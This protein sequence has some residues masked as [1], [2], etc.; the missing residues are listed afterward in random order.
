MAETAPLYCDYAATAPIRPEVTAAIAP[1]L[2]RAVGNPAALHP[3]GEEAKNTLEQARTLVANVFASATKNV[4]EEDVLFT[5]GGTEANNLAIKGLALANPRGKHIVTSTIEHPA[6]HEPL[7]QLEKWHGFEVDYAPVTADGVVD[8]KAFEQLLRPDTTLVSIM[9]V[10]NEIGTIQPIAEIAAAAKNVGALVH[11]DAVQAGHS[12][13]LSELY[14]HVDAMSVTGH[15]LGA[16]VGTGALIVDAKLPLEP[17]FSGGGQQ[18]DRRPGTQNLVGAVGLAT[19]LLYAQED[20]QNTAAQQVLADRMDWVVEQLRKEYP[21]LVR[22][23]EEA[24]RVPG[25]LHL[26]FPWIYGE[27]VM[28]DL[29]NQGIYAATGSACHS[30]MTEPSSVLLALGAEEEDAKA[31]LRFSVGLDFS[32]EDAQR[33]VGA[34]TKAVPADPRATR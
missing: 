12:L 29:V 34:L 11:T 22:T 4:T 5:S 9:T 6:V 1:W 14:S 2:S 23:A 13:D 16:Q 27:T 24:P 7:K 20:A 28:V 17:L 33:L 10:N 19:A 15:K 21:T 18:W 31:G 3:M 25:I 30:G 8:L 26:R 32:Y